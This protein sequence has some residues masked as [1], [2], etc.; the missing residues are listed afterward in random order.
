MVQNDL[1]LS[2]SPRKPVLEVLT[3]RIPNTLLLVVTALTIAI[4]SGVALG[5]V[6]GRLSG[7]K[8][9]TPGEVYYQIS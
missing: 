2:F 6:A 5:A 4:V 3:T 7:T 1:E 9:T 8:F